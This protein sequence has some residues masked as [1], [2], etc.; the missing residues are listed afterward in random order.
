M[1]SDKAI[2][3]KNSKYFLFGNCSFLTLTQSLFEIKRICFISFVLTL[4][5]TISSEFE[6][7]A[8]KYPK[9]EY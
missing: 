3:D 7:I 1:I 4:H 9:I 5:L 6:V 2:I 8:S